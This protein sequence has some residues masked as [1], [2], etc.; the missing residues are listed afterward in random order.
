MTILK[1]YKAE[2]LDLDYEAQIYK[3]AKQFK[4]KVEVEDDEINTKKKK[5]YQPFIYFMHIIPLISSLQRNIRKGKDKM[6]SVCRC[7]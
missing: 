3:T 4:Q 6:N 2:E 7:E 1:R 5:L